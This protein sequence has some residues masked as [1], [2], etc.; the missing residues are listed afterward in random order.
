M[1]EFQIVGEF[2][3]ALTRVHDQLDRERI[4]IVII[5][6]LV[7][8]SMENHL[9]SSSSSSSSSM[10]IIMIAT[11]IIIF[12]FFHI[13]PNNPPKAAV[14]AD[15]LALVF[16]ATQ[17]LDY[18]THSRFEEGMRVSKVLEEEEEKIDVVWGLVVQVARHCSADAGFRAH[19]GGHQA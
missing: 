19:L 3:A 4:L 12:S 18:Q 14:S 2:W 5:M 6:L 15:I 13:H 9:H 1:G 7:M 11:N 17:S 16:V 8:T 10:I